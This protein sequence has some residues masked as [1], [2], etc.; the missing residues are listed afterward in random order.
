MVSGA[1]APAEDGRVA[2]VTALVQAP[3]SAGG[4]PW[5]WIIALLLA[6][7]TGVLLERSGV[8]GTG[9]V[10]IGLLLAVTALAGFEAGRRGRR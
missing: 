1:G 6:L 9:M 3:P 10:A 7:A 8:A 2:A 4:H 5:G